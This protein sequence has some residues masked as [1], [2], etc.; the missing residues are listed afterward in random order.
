LAAGAEAAGAAAFVFAE[1]GDPV[2]VGGAA[3]LAE[4]GGGTGAEV[5][6]G[7]G[8]DDAG[9]TALSDCPVG[10]AT[11]VCA[12][13]LS[14]KKLNAMRTRRT[15]FM[16]NVCLL[17]NWTAGSGTTW[18]RSSHQLAQRAARRILDLIASLERFFLPQC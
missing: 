17:K 3:V 1:S 18:V 4:T 2:G 11:G 16:G 13:A 6:S 12:K 9:G 7:V 14:V 10:L 8:R 15:L 5:A